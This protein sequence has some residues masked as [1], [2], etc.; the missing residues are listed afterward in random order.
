MSQIILQPTSKYFNAPRSFELE[1]VALSSA[2]D[3][4][5]T[6][7]WEYADIGGSNW[8][9]VLHPTAETETL[10]VPNNIAAYKSADFRCVI[11][12]H[13]SVEPSTI[14]ISDTA[15][16]RIF[17]S[18][19]STAFK[20]STRGASH[21]ISRDASNLEVTDWPSLNN[22]F[23]NSTLGA[24]TLIDATNHVDYHNIQS[25]LID[26]AQSMPLP[27]GG[28]IQNVTGLAPNGVS[29]QSSLTISGVVVSPNGEPVQLSVYGLRVEVANGASA[30]TVRDAIQVALATYDDNNIYIDNLTVSGSDSLLYN[31]VDHKT[32]QVLNSS[33]FGITITGAVVSPAFAGYGTWVK[34]YE[35][36]VVY[37]T[38]STTIH[39]WRRTA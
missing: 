7:Q 3:S 9:P 8:S 38:V 10:I 12:E 19:R 33:Q 39:Y 17:N 26:L 4:W 2:Q 31:H 36:T 22:L 37:L 25:A 6:F 35:E 27:V 30:Q 14:T 18:R 34:F 32:H 15:T 24:P 5:V 21:L 16:M 29:Q 13:Y 11:T 28:V 1:C 23:P 20:T